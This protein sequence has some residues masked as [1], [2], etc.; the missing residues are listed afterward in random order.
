MLTSDKPLVTIG[1]PTYS[2][3]QLLKEAV[4]AARAQSYARIEILI[5]QNPHANPA[6]TRT[7]A[8]YCREQQSRDS[9]VRYQIQPRNIGPEANFNSIADDARGAYLSLIGDDDRL[10]PNA[11]ESLVNVIG[12]HAV[13]F[14]K[15]YY[16][17]A[18]G[19][20]LEDITRSTNAACGLEDLPA[21]NVENPELHAWRRSPTVESALFRSETFR[22]ARFRK[23]LDMC[24]IELFIRLARSG[25][26]FVFYPGYVCDYRLHADSTTGGGF[27]EAGKLARI[28][29]PLE[30]DADTEPYK[31][32]LMEYMVFT[33]FRTA[34]LQGEIDSARWLRSSQY[35]PRR[36]CSR[37]KQ[38]VMDTC[39]T[40]PYC[41]SY[42]YRTLHMIK[43]GRS[44]DRRY[45]SARERI[46]GDARHWRSR[47]RPSS[48]QRPDQ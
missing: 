46:G 11:I 5:S 13:A 30:V 41:G 38:L 27:R 28:L 24:D 2:R 14:G 23:E 33:G 37:K 26:A 19:A 3:P 45:S 34:L 16:V 6:I 21:G 29:E 20:P 47:N 48:R 25:C 8:S 42:L 36:F 12:P 4:A 9:R 18:F 15:R 44:F 43:N 40:L 10:R 17:N 39:I 35:Y 31:R 7:I 1:I 32:R 22:L